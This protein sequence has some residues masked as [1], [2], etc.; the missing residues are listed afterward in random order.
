MNEE[1]AKKLVAS[2]RYAVLGF[3]IGCC[4]IG[5][6]LLFW[7]N[8]FKRYLTYA[9]IVANLPFLL[10]F[11][12][13][14]ITESVLTLLP[15]TKDHPPFLF[16]LVYPCRK[17]TILPAAITIS[18]FAAALIVSITSTEGT[19]VL[20][21]KK[22]LPLVTLLYFV[23]GQLTYMVWNTLLY[24]KIK[25]PGTGRLFFVLSI[26]AL[27]LISC[28]AYWITGALEQDYASLFLLASPLTLIGFLSLQLEEKPSPEEEGE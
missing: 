8:I 23:P 5:I 17:R 22:V 28:L 4:L 9:E 26:N 16:P 14:V 18:T 11:L 15:K 21:D 27:F 25:Q 2:L 19:V 12:G 24:I 7:K 3:L 6:G 20:L 1:K 10:A 13:F